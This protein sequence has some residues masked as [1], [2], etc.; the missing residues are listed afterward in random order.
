MPAA[1]QNEGST[2]KNLALLISFEIRVI[3]EVKIN[4]I[5]F[6]TRSRPQRRPTPARIRDE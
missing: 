5:P 4:P 3:T 2:R 6:G 1:L